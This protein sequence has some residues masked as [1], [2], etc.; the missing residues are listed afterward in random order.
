MPLI[1]GNINRGADDQQVL[2]DGEIKPLV[3]LRRSP[4]HLAALSPRV[5]ASCLL[6]L[7]IAQ[8][9]VASTDSK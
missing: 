3:M 5:C 1:S 8:H 6:S 4:A 9:Q 2:Q 7:Q